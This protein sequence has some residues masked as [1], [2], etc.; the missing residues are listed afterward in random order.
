VR[1]A[2]GMA[3]QVK[4]EVLGVIENMTGDIFG[5]GGGQAVAD[6]FHVPLLGSIPLQA[7]LRV[8]GDAGVPMVTAEPHSEVAMTFAEIAG[9]VAQ[10]VAKKAALS[11]PVLEV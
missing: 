8:G 2:I 3:H 1:R 6:K 5:K 9:K 7:G 11:L 10:E 4:T